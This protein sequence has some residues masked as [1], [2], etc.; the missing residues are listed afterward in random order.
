[1]ALFA[2]SNLALDAHKVVLGRTW[3][4]IVGTINL[5]I[6]TTKGKGF[7][8]SLWPADL[9]GLSLWESEHLSFQPTVEIDVSTSAYQRPCSDG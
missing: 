3:S 7:G 9:Q 4:R 8:G 1:M 6:C 5:K 2:N